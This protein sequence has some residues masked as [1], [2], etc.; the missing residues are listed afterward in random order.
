MKRILFLAFSF[1]GI[2]TFAQEAEKD[3]GQIHGNFQTNTQYYLRDTIIDPTGTAFPDE[4]LLA[5]GFLN[6]SL[7]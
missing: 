2:S 6:L 3:Y 1:F 7:F 4:R 5:A